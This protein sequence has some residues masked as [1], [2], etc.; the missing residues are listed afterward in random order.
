MPGGRGGSSQ[1]VRLEEQVTVVVDTSR[2]EVAACMLINTFLG[3]WDFGANGRLLKTT[4]IET[5]V[6]FIAE[7]YTL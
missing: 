3:K 4:V 5:T 7:L 6:W 1:A 2:R